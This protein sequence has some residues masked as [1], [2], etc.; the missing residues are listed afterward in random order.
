MTEDLK[1]ESPMLD[2]I[3]RR[4]PFVVPDGF[5]D[6]FPHLVQARIAKPE[7]AWRRMLIGFWNTHWAIRTAIP[8]AAALVV[9]FLLRIQA[10]TDSAH[11]TFT[12]DIKPEEL[13]DWSM[14]DEDLFAVLPEEEG[15]NVWA[16]PLSEEELTGYLDHEG[17]PLEL[18][19]EEL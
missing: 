7:P 15:T 4:D 17:I 14:N 18:I 5:F 1:N 12:T 6:R 13:S 8:V 2:A 11:A 16:E 10:T 3:P 19:I 9:I